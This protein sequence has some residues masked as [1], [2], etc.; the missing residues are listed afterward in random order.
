MEGFH[1]IK[2]G[3]FGDVEPVFEVKSPVGEF[4]VSLGSSG[5]QDSPLSSFMAAR[6]LVMIGSDAE[7]EEI[8]LARVTLMAWMWKY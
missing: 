3:R 6:A 7:D 8:L 4:P 5:I 2:A 1:E